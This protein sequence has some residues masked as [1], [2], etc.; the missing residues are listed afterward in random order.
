MGISLFPLNPSLSNPAS[1]KVKIKNMKG[2]TTTEVILHKLF[3]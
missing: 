3:T 2:L 1:Q